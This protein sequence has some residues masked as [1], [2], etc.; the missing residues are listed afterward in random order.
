MPY[1]FSRAN[2]VPEAL[3]ASPGAQLR[4]GEAGSALPRLETAPSPGIAVSHLG[5][6]TCFMRPGWRGGAPA[7]DIKIPP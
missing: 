4:T 7:T 5:G 6:G 3:R 2:T 1:P